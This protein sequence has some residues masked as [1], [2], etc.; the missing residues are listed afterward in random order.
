MSIKQAL[1]LQKKKVLPVIKR[2]KIKASVTDEP[3][4]AEFDNIDQ[5][6]IKDVSN[7]NKYQETIL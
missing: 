7:L 4:A 6:V 5:Q 1:H 2:L 3:I